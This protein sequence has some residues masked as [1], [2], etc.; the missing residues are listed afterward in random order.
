MQD[1]VGKHVYLGHWWVCQINNAKVE[2]NT[3]SDLGGD[4]GAAE[5][6]RSPFLGRCRGSIPQEVSRQ[7][8]V[9]PIPSAANAISRNA[10]DRPSL[11]VAIRTSLRDALSLPQIPEEP[12]RGAPRQGRAASPTNSALS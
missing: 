7:A 10:S 6:E 4:P 9:L 12:S 2:R 5:V 8:D 11:R 3:N 1:G